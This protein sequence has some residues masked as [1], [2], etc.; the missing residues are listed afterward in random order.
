[1]SVFSDAGKTL[2]AAFSATR[3]VAELA[4]IT[5]GDEVLTGFVRNTGKIVNIALFNAAQMTEIEAEIEMDR[6]LKEHEEFMEKRSQS[7][8]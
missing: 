5:A 1:M 6:F 4:E 3:K 2:S 8:Q 7:S